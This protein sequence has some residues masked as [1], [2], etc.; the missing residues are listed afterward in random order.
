MP[1]GVADVVVAIRTDVLKSRSNETFHES[2]DAVIVEDGAEP[3][4]LV[5]EGYEHCPR[6]TVVVAVADFGLMSPDFLE[7]VGDLANGVVEQTGQCEVA[8]GLEKSDLLF[9]ELELF[10]FIPN[11]YDSI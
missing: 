10:H 9:G 8:E 3:F 6:R 7:G 11:R 5:D 1:G 2:F 4:V